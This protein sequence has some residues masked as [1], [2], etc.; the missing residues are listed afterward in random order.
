MTLLGLVMGVYS[1]L[2]NGVVHSLS[3]SAV[4]AT[5]RNPEL[6]ELWKGNSLGAVPLHREIEETRLKFGV[7]RRGL[8]GVDGG[9]GGGTVEVEGEQ[10]VAF[11]I[12][13]DDGRGVAELE[14]GGKYV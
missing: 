7:V 4:I 11:G 1:F 9:G 14:K 5:T 10:H 6:D 2:R 13:H 12:V 3:F 8:Q